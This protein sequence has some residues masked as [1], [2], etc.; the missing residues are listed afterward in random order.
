MG[1]TTPLRPDQADHVVTVLRVVDGDTLSCSVDLGFGIHI[2]R[3]IR[4][5]GLDTP[6]L[7]GPMKAE[8]AALKSL[9]QQLCPPGIMLLMRTF[10]YEVDHYGR[11][12][13]TLYF[14]DGT[15][16]L[17][18]F[19]D[20]WKCTSRDARVGKTFAKAGGIPASPVE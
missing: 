13:A 7:K 9:L 6:E 10:H 16:L 14:A 15:P 3:I 1:M 17:D 8:G 2:D 11:I 20:R 19:P 4:L 12:V 18:R 5:D